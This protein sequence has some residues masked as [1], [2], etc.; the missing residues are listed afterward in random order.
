[1]CPKNSK[2]P[3]FLI[4]GVCFVIIL[5]A[6]CGITLI[7]NINLSN[8]IRLNEKVASDSMSPNSHHDDYDGNDSDNDNNDAG[9]VTD[10]NS[11]TG[12]HANVAGGAYQHERHNYEQNHPKNIYRYDK[13][14]GMMSNINAA[15]YKQHLLQQQQ[16]H[17]ISTTSTT[18]TTT[19]TPLSLAADLGGPSNDKSAVKDFWQNNKI[20]NMDRNVD[21][22]QIQEINAITS[23]VSSVA[24]ETS[25]QH[26]DKLT[27]T[28]PVLAASSLSPRQA[29]A[30]ND[31]LNIVDDSLSMSTMTTT[32]TTV[33]PSSP[34]SSLPS[35]PSVLVVTDKNTSMIDYE[36][37]A[38]IV[39][40]SDLPLLVFSFFFFFC[41]S[42]EF[43][44]TFFLCLQENL[45]S[46]KQIQCIIKENV[47][48]E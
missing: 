36:K 37:R 11:G 9:D 47:R 8:I 13:E 31:L 46:R 14:T 24:L 17:A 48:L 35:A 19:T 20:I 45:F 33:S 30:A 29:V 39:E 6:V 44:F 41:S 27:T 10:T 4:G 40:V 38:H 16:Q 42:L 2:A 21:T 18:I 7:N 34:A 26:F 1:M 23:S 32:P 28:A 5:V 12:I 22:L 15:D 3:V 25:T 43:F